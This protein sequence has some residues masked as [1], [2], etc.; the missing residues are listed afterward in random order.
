MFSDVRRQ[1][2]PRF[3]T[4]TLLTTLAT[5]AFVLSSVLLVVALSV[6]DYVRGSVVQKLETGQRL[7]VRLEE[8]RIEDLRAHV[9]NLADNPTLKAALHT[10]QAERRPASADVRS[11]LVATIEKELDR[12]AARLQPDVV[13]ARDLD[14]AALAVSG[15]LAEQWMKGFP[16]G[17]AADAN[18]GFIVLASGVYRA[19][20]LPVALEG[21]EVG[22]VQL[23]QALGDRYARELSDLSDADTLIVSGDRIVATTLP[24]PAAAAITGAA[25]G[26]TA[27]GLTRLAGEEYAVR[28]LLRDGAT[29]VY[30]LDSI[31]QS[32]WPL[33]R[34]SLQTIGSIALGGFLLAAIASLWLARTISRP[35]DTLSHALTDMTRARAFDRHLPLTG[36][37]LE[38]D[39]L[40]DAF[41]TMTGAIMSAEAE[42]LNAY[43]EAIRALAMALDARD[44][45]TSGHS[46]RVSALS[47]AIGRQMRLDAPTLEVLRLGALL[48]DIGKI[49]VSDHLLRKA[50]PLSVE[51]FEVIKTHPTVGSRILRN[52]R[53]LD[54]HLPIVELHHERPDGGGYPFGL[55]GDAIPLPARIVHVADAYDAMTSGRAYRPALPASVGLAELHRCA[56]T[57]FDPAVVRALSEVV[58]RDA[59]GP[60]HLAAGVLAAEFAPEEPAAAPRAARQAVNPLDEFASEGEPA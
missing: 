5:V 18:A 24:G 7:L 1:A 41:N 19:V 21:V 2:P 27:G 56:G 23:A 57:D 49:G 47:V 17:G 29:A 26:F 39:S 10:Y 3:V 35:I 13:A 55:K 15:R 44:P 9:A 52:V 20:T 48:H 43:L 11:Q 60:A 25:S 34:S 4:R 22:S 31:D 51:E 38:V 46:E 54:P 53:F 50:G 58:A 32:A 6:R 14:G 16:D 40:T 36:A 28:P 30:V 8:R 45:Y 42:T 33:V 12:V 37:S 59:S